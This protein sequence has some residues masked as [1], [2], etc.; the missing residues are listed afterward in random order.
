MIKGFKLIY[1]GSE[2]KFLAAEFHKKC[3]NMGPTFIIV[4]S[5]HFKIFGGFT[6]INWLS[7]GGHK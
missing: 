4:K 6:D 1:R 7:S 3:D 5:E 2:N